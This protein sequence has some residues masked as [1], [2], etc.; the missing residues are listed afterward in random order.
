MIIFGIYLRYL[1]FDL[2]PEFVRCALEFVEH[3]SYLPPD[4]RQLFGAENQQG[5]KEKENGLGKA[6]SFIILG[7]AKRRQSPQHSALSSLEIKAGH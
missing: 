4:F 3:L 6:H 5:Q 2:R 7:K 1:G